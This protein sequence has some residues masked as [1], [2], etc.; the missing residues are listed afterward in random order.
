MAVFMNTFSHSNQFSEEAGNEIVFHLFTTPIQSG[1]SIPDQ[2][3]RI[4]ITFI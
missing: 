4:W 2:S 3:V 1:V